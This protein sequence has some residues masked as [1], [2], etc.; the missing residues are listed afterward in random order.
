M[1][2]RRLSLTAEAD[3]EKGFQLSKVE[4]WVE[5]GGLVPDS[6]LLRRLDL[7]PVQLLQLTP[8]ACSWSH[9]LAG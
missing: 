2:N 9:L 5:G 6:A 7:V 4:V 8:L 3:L 1:S